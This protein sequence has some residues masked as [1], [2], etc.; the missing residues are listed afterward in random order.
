MKKTLLLFLSLVMLLG[1]VVFPSSAEPLSNGASQFSDDATLIKSGYLGETVK[2]RLSDFKKAL[3]SNKISAIVVTSLPEEGTGTLFLSSSRLVKGQSIP[4]SALE[5]LKFVPASST[6]SES[7]F[8]FT[9]GNL[10]GGAEL[11]CVIRLLDKKN[12]APTVSSEAQLTVTTQKGISYFGALSAEDPEGDALH[13]RITSYP[14]RGTLALLDAETGEF[15]YTPTGSY[16]GTDR[17]SYVVRD[18]YGNF[19]TEQTVEVKVKSRTSTLVYEDVAGTDTELAAIAMT[20]AG[21]ILGRLS[22]DSMFF[23]PEK[24][25]TKG[26]F[27]VMVMK[28]AGVSPT[29]GLYDTC[30]DDNEEIPTSIRRYIATAQMKGFV[31][32]SFDG[33]GLYF[34][35]DAPITGAE[36]AVI[37]CNVFGI[38]TDGSESVFAAEDAVPTWAIPAVSALYERDIPVLGATEQMTR[39]DAVKML[40]RLSEQ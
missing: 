7:G 1:L 21:V 12:E 35:A 34:E 24:T 9:A 3:G 31:H 40:Y 32:G 10:C 20:D 22:G 26:D 36:A 28:V 38:S 2:F 6:I 39:A 17:F 11:K 16:R 23:D 8:T 25:V 27:T 14:K 30:F 19:S 15:R 33:T 37:V 29:P 18:E 5:L 4:A 13:F